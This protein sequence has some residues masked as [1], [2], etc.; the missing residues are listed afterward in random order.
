MTRAAVL[1]LTLDDTLGK[2]NCA[3]HLRTVLFFLF[4]R[5]FWRRELAREV[6]QHGLECAHTPVTQNKKQARVLLL[7]QL[8]SFICG[9]HDA[10][11]LLGIGSRLHASQRRACVGGT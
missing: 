10:T 11:Q 9:E 1:T 8:Y 3:G 5:F 4:F 2:G 6:S 7:Q